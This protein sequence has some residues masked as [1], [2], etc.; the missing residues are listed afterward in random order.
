MSIF[1]GFISTVA[2]TVIKM[3]TVFNQ[4]FTQY[5]PILLYWKQNLTTTSRSRSATILFTRFCKLDIFTHLLLLCNLRRQYQHQF[6]DSSMSLSIGATSTLQKNPYLTLTQ[7]LP[8]KRKDRQLMLNFKYS[9]TSARSSSNC[10]LP[11]FQ[12]PHSELS[13]L[14]FPRP[15]SRSD[16]GLTPTLETICPSASVRRQKKRMF[17]INVE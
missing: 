4:A 10:T 1:N 6:S 8:W 12:L 2:A 9:P 11:H 5:S 16:C 13:P 3:L 14:T 15:H 17:F 7:L